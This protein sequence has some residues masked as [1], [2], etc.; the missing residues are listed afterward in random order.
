MMPG[1]QTGV[2]TVNGTV[3]PA[4]VV[5]TQS[6]MTG[7]PVDGLNASGLPRRRSFRQH[8]RVAAF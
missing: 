5:T 2:V 4:A 6:A 3:S 7:M 1:R 8:R